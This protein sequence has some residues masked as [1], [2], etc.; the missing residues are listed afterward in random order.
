MPPLG[1]CQSPSTRRSAPAAASAPAAK[2]VSFLAPAAHLEPGERT[3]RF[4]LGDGALLVDA[5]GQSR[6]SLQDYA[7]AMVDELE[8]PRHERRLF[9]VA[10]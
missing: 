3:G 6:I 9:N 1:S 5:D 7:V 10:Y 2:S 4:R 8:T